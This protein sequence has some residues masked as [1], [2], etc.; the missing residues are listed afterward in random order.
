MP[1]ACHRAHTVENVIDAVSLARKHGYKV[2]VDFIFGL[3]G[4][5]LQDRRESLK[6]MK[7]V[8]RL[9]AR[10]HPHV[11]APL[12]QTAFAK[13]RPG[14]TDPFLLNALEELKNQQGLYENQSR[15]Q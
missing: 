14:S 9:G 5:T 12:P 6:A 3:P 4:E 8:V 1:D 7:T 11:F 10:I 15:P 2:I 13:E